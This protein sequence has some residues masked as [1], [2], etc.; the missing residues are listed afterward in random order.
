M[1]PFHSSVCQ[2]ESNSLHCPHIPSQVTTLVSGYTV[3]GNTI[4]TVSSTQLLVLF[5]L[6]LYHLICTVM[7]ISKDLFSKTE[8][9]SAT[10]KNKPR[11]K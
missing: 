6:E 7:T 9:P 8:M 5:G 4:Q 3:L 11:K 1:W 10:V 2:C